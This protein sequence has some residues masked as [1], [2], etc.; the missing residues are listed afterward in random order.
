MVDLALLQSVSY[1]VGALGV[2]V[3]AAYYVL[4]LNETRINRR[5]ALT[6][7]LMYPVFH[8]EEGVR[9]LIELGYTK[10]SDYDDFKKKYDSS[11]NPDHCAKRLAVWNTYDAIGHQYRL[12]LLDT[13]SVYSAC[14]TQVTNMWVKYKPIIDEYRKS[15]YGRDTY[16]DFE[17]LAKDMMRIKAERDPLHTGSASILRPE[18]YDKALKS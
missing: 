6:N 10:W 2:C 15:D 7:S 18:D 16:G 8:T 12:G 4:N 1:I 9:R 17:F 13:E 14:N 3:A 5:I 11:V